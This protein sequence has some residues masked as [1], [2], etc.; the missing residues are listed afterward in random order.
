MKRIICG[1]YQI[2]SE[3]TSKLYIGSSVR[4]EQRWSEHRWSLRRGTHTSP[5]LQRAW[6]KHG[7]QNFSFSVIE[8]CAR[9]Q[10]LEREQLHITALRPDYN[11]MLRV[12]V[13]SKEM[14][15]RRNASLRARAAGITHCPRGHEYTEANTYRS[16]AKKRICRACN[17][18]RVSAVY[19]AETTEQREAR[20]QQRRRYY[21]ATRD[22]Q[23]G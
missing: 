14:L 5:R 11:S 16:K 18:L 7:E 10:L 12:R 3:R 13:V 21:L 8:E 2:K 15:A 23:I 22:N 17:A 20:R 4:V 9:D 1:I 6:Q 19:A